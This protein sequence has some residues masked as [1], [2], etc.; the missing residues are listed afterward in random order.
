MHCSLVHFLS[1][2]R[3]LFEQ[4]YTDFQHVIVH[5]ISMLLKKMW[6]V[7]PTIAFNRIHELGGPG[8][9]ALTLIIFWQP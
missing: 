5:I 3:N 4:F 9:P 7:S 1:V 2:L 8:D 6:T